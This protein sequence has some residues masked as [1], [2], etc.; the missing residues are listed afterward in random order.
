MVDGE[1]ARITVVSGKVVQRGAGV[2]GGYLIGAFSGSFSEFVYIQHQSHSI[3]RK[4]DK[5]MVGEK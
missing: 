4:A 3:Y 5:D 2:I 1:E